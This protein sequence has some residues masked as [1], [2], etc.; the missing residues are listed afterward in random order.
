MLF[1]AKTIA[2]P[3]NVVVRTADT[4]VLIIALYNIPILHTGAKLW[5]EVG[6]GSKNTLRNISVTDMHVNLGRNLCNALPG[7]HA[8]TGSDFTA[9]F[10]SKGKPIE[11]IEKEQDSFESSWRT[12]VFWTDI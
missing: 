11:E 2:E 8:L 5:L 12:W 6:I 10:S 9:S 4:D 1:H 7:Y 3:K